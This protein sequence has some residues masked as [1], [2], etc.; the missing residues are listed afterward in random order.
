MKINIHIDDLVVNK[1]LRTG[2][3][4]T[5]LTISLYLHEEMIVIIINIT[6][7]AVRLVATPTDLK[8]CFELVTRAFLVSPD[9][10]VL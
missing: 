6:A 7:I 4:Q 9:V 3:I 5:I 8:I 2:P 1:Q 10:A